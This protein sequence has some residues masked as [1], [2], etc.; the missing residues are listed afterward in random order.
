MADLDVARLGAGEIGS[1]EDIDINDFVLEAGFPEP[2]MEF[3]GCCVG[4]RRT[5]GLRVGKSY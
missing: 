3:D 1:E 2:E 4:T 5:L